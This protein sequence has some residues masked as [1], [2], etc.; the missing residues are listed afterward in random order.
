MRSEILLK[1]PMMMPKM[2]QMVNL[3]MVKLSNRIHLKGIKISYKIRR[4]S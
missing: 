3:I 4:A 2:R 1:Y